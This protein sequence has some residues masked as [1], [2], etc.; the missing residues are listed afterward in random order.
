MLNNT[1]DSGIHAT[2][3]NKYCLIHAIQSNKTLT[4]SNK[5]F[6]LLEPRRFFR[7]QFQFQLQYPLLT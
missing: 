5:L 2:Q 3:A 6:E 7:F 4:N 1:F